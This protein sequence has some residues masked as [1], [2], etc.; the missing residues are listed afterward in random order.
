MWGQQ[1]VWIT[2]WINTDLNSYPSPPTS[3]RYYFDP[4]GPQ[5]PHL[6]SGFDYNSDSNIL[7]D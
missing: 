6:E 1:A 7:K 4:S 3:L 2:L 5:F